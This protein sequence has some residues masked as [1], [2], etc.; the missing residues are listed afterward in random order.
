[1]SYFMQGMHQVLLFCLGFG[2]NLG[3]LEF[4]RHLCLLNISSQVHPFKS[5]SCDCTDMWKIH[6]EGPEI[7]FSAICRT[8]STTILPL[9]TPR[10]AKLRHA[11]PADIE[12]VLS[13]K[14]SLQAPPE[15]S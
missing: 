8:G 3:S 10:S 1:M 11:E 5:S 6:A 4:M 15:T 9:K 7:H 12:T 13:R 14:A 2:Q